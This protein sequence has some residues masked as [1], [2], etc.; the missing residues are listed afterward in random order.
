MTSRVQREL[1]P[2]REEILEQVG[3]WIA[4]VSILNF[5]LR[6]AAKAVGISGPA[7][8]RHFDSRE[9][10]IEALVDHFEARIER[11]MDGMDQSAMS[12][13]EMM[14]LHTTQPEPA[15]MD[16]E[17]LGMQMFALSLA[18]RDSLGYVT[19]KV[20]KLQAGW[21]KR[22]LQR[23]GLAENTAQ[24]LAELLLSALRGLSLDHYFHQ[25]PA[26]F[27]RGVLRLADALEGW[28]K[29]SIEDQQ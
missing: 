6:A 11:E 20:I 29:N 28:V 5:S 4:E 18:E 12:V 14:R 25:D 23:D 3:G 19:E 9:G 21:I 16:M 7:M 24:E 2:R 26:R 17:K 1:T 22:R 8:L 10:L 13:P 15:F 27:K